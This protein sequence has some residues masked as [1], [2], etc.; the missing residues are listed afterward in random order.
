MRI[1]LRVSI[2]VHDH[3]MTISIPEPDIR[4]LVAELDTARSKAAADAHEAHARSMGCAP[5]TS[6]DP[7]ASEL[8][9][10]TTAAAVIELTAQVHHLTVAT[11]EHTAALERAR[12]RSQQI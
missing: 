6:F 3:A 5:E 4:A 12:R 10:L 11:R 2:V 7:P 9:G 8:I 1:L